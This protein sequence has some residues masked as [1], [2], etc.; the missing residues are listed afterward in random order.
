MAGREGRPIGGWARKEVVRSRSRISKTATLPPPLPLSL[1]LSLCLCPL[2]L[3]LQTAQDVREAHWLR[4]W[5]LS[6]PKPLPPS[7]RVVCVLCSHRQTTRR[8][9]LTRRR[10]P[11]RRRP[12]HKR[13]F[14]LLL[15]LPPPPRRRWPQT[16]PRLLPASSIPRASLISCRSV[17][18]PTLPRPPAVR[19]TI[20][21]SHVGGDCTHLHTHTC[22]HTHVHT[23]MYTHVHSLQVT[24]GGDS[25]Y[26]V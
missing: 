20:V 6:L 18:I 15:P 5:R 10:P 2:L 1:P 13:P 21:A 24:L 4:R 11:I 23:H 25:V 17:R 16:C 8:R 22:I 9:P 26:I 19:M 12:L 14:L 7:R 3:L